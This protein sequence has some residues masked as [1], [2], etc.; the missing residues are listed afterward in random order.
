MKTLT[1]FVACMALVAGMKA[2][3]KHS[4]RFTE[5]SELLLNQEELYRKVKLC[6]HLPKVEVDSQ[7][8]SW[9]HFCY[10]L[11][12][13][14]EQEVIF[15][16]VYNG[17]LWT[18]RLDQHSGFPEFQFRVVE[19]IKPCAKQMECADSQGRVWKNWCYSDGSLVEFEQK[20]SN[21]GTDWEFVED[22]IGAYELFDYRRI[23][24]K[25]D[26]EQQK[27]EETQWSFFW[28]VFGIDDQDE[29]ND[30][31][32]S[33]SDETN[34]E[35]FDANFADIDEQSDLI[36]VPIEEKSENGG[37][38]T[39]E[40]PKNE[41]STETPENCYE[42]ETDNSERYFWVEFDSKG[43]K[44][45]FE[46][47]ARGN[48]LLNNETKLRIPTDA[49]FESDKNVT[50]RSIPLS[51]EVAQSEDLRLEADKEM[52][53]CIGWMMGRCIRSRRRQRRR[54]MG[55]INSIRFQDTESQRISL[56]CFR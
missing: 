20:A 53:G 4:M 50:T 1:A 22:K 16:R 12:S 11:P 43:K 27:F 28:D 45:E 26:A 36:E 47:D 37:K 52:R 9:P 41:N 34:E 25:V 6:T 3:P 2:F 29:E 39:A 14:T 38:N 42:L 30:G 7:G 56:L 55:C 51:C 54:D 49:D 21:N 23:E 17:D 48:F 46:M 31:F 33:D 40:Q 10:S 8:H 24:H 35:Q 32:L 5:L 19:A 15:Q 44:V 18:Y 13:N